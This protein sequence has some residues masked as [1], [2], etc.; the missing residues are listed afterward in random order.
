[1]G[2]P[3][4]GRSGPPARRPVPTK[5]RTVQGKQPGGPSRPNP[6][7]RRWGSV[8]RRGAGAV[9]NPGDWRDHPGRDEV[10]SSRRPGDEGS[11]Q[12]ERW[13]EV[14]RPKPSPAAGRRAGGKSTDKQAVLA[15]DLLS[16]L[17]RAVGPA[18]ASRLAPQLAQAVRAYE[19]DRYP[20]AL[21]ALRPIA[22]VATEAPA[23]R[24]LLGLTLYRM[25]R[26]RPA[27]KE[28]EAF[29][30]LTSSY[31]QHPVLADC[32]RALGHWKAVEELWGDLR[33]A[34]PGAELVAEGDIVAAGALADRGDVAGAIRL[35]E[36][37]QAGRKRVR[38]HDLRVSYALA[39]LYERSGD[40]PRARELLRTVAAHDPGFVDVGARLAALS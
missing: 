13:V 8:A 29:R 22:N 9:T 18:E 28:L 21:R 11:W 30:A 31:D 34:S 36:R 23:V 14:A 1:M 3:G 25:G 26:W 27:I 4:D 32:H 16:E 10:S 17:R 20:D 40:L 24:E 33:Q 12:P 2:R 15:H 7:G 19:R 35:L 37:A 5:R 39:D 6:P 38:P